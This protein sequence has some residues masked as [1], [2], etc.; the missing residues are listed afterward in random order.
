[1][2]ER[3]EKIQHIGLFNDARPI[4]FKFGR[5]TLIYADNGRG[6]STLSS[7][8]H[9]LATGDAT[10]VTERQT[11]D[12][13]GPMEACLQFGSG[14]KSTFKAGAGW[15]V[16]RPELTVFDAG[17]IDRNVHS[18]GVITP[19]HRE[20]LLAF[21]LGTKAVAAQGV[22]EKAEKKLLDAKSDLASAEAKI[23]GMRGELSIEGFRQLPQDLNIADEVARLETKLVDTR[24]V[25]RILARPNADRISIVT[26]DLAAAFEVLRETLDDV[27]DTA[28]ELVQEHLRRLAHD[29]AEHWLEDGQK[30]DSA[31]ACPYCGQDTSEVSLVKA[32]RS[33]FNEAYIDLSER[34]DALSTALSDGGVSGYL[35]S[36]EGAVRQRRELFKQ[37]EEHCTLEAVQIDSEELSKRLSVASKLVVDLVSAKRREMWKS[38]GTEDE[39]NAASVAWRSVYELVGRANE[40]VDE[41]VRTI[42]AFKT[43]LSAASEV[44]ILAEIQRAK[45]QQTRHETAAVEAVRALVEAGQSQKEA[46]G[47]KDR[48]RQALKAIMKTTLDAYR[49]DINKYLSQLGA[50]FS[51]EEITT[52]FRG[53]APKSDYGILLRGRSVASSSVAPSF[54]T[55]LS[56]GDKRTLAFAF[57]AASTLGDPQLSAKVVVVDDPVSSLDRSRRE[58]TR[59]ILRD[60]AEKAAQLV[61]LT[62]DANLVREL[63]DALR[64]HPATSDA[65]I[66]RLERIASGYTGFGQ[67]DIDRECETEYY[68]NYRIIEEFRDSGGDPA[69]AARAI[70]PLMEGYLHRRF[71]KLLPT[72]Q[73][74]GSVITGIE[75]ATAPSPLC[76]A[77]GLVA[78]LREINKYAGQ[79]HHDTNPG[80]RETDSV[81]DA[82][83][84]VYS[85]RALAIIYGEY[86]GS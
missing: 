61:V 65:V 47:E 24:N 66:F 43:T 52:S 45:L 18:G 54:A 67:V 39:F 62:H 69:P 34:V 27:H 85:R 84:E 59:R 72:G 51:I 28:E 41:N 13:S 7:L 33:H 57:F 3:I 42:E 44:E 63:R 56:D 50:T 6:K 17:F 35:E 77:Q 11:V 46:E 49:D 15:D 1:M 22:L 48:A 83:V 12:D 78:E 64:K 79:F 30:F 31:T 81:S 58:L 2:L 19:A 16:H 71:P 5:S 14:Q 26:I 55:A 23:D 74:L 8:L 9:S 37:W 75:N 25:G 10:G 29:E 21:A 70:R 80:Y 73:M 36:V 32:Y 40:V 76:H 86:P 4:A 82:I 20:R 68:R 60:I 38:I 53:N